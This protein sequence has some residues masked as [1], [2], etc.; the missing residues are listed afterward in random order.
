MSS[1]CK[2]TA[3]LSVRGTKSPCLRAEFRSVSSSPLSGCLWLLGQRLLCAHARILL[4]HPTVN[5]LLFLEEP[6][7]TCPKT[8]QGICRLDPV[9]PC[10]V[11]QL[12]GAPGA[13]CAQGRGMLL[14]TGIL[15]FLSHMSQTSRTQDSCTKSTPLAHSFFVLFCFVIKTLHKIYCI[16][17]SAR[18]HVTHSHT[19]GG[20]VSVTV[21]TYPFKNC[22]N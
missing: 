12:L 4:P 2:A 10:T 8:S 20:Y 11:A 13:M 16:F 19:Y 15:A 5:I 18:I 6:Y 21:R 1:H 22:S 9:S 14:W 17:R 3:V 7:Q